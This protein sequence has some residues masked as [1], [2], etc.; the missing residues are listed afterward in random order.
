M[1]SDAKQTPAASTDANDSEMRATDC[2]HVCA[3]ERNSLSL[4]T[5]PRTA[6]LVRDLLLLAMILI[7]ANS[8][9]VRAQT[10]SPLQEW[11]YSG[12]IILARLFELNL[13]Q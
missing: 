1:P 5:A 8:R 2:C 7:T 11:Q 6:S 10:P 3:A 12:G 4:P 9:A 13:P